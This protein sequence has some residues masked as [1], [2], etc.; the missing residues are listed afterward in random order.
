MSSRRSARLS[1]AAPAIKEEP[2]AKPTA[3]KT[4]AA[5]RKRKNASEP[6]LNEPLVK[7]EAPSTPKRKRPA[8]SNIPPATPT[9]A[10][11]GLMTAHNLG[12]TTPP[13]INRLAVPDGTNAPLVSPE[14]H[15]V[16][17]SKP[18]AQVSPSKVSQIKTTT[19]NILEDALAH[20]IKVEPKLKAVIEQNPCRVFSPEGLAEEIDPFKSLV[21]GII[22]QQVRICLKFAYYICFRVHTI[23]LGLWRCREVH[24]SQIRRDVQPRRRRH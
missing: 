7:G 21:S 9:P 10:A 12:N 18:L 20:L 14:T 23:I 19:E 6:E 4:T 16:I 11:I 15:R 8:K 5:N 1:A 24:P 2:V 13:A 22:S 17:S 3:P